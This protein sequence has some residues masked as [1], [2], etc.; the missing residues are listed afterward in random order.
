MPGTN[1]HTWQ[2]YHVGHLLVTI[3]LDAAAGRSAERHQELPGLTRRLIALTETER[4]PVTW[5]VS[6]PAHSAATSLILRS[7]IEHEIAILG[8]LNWVGPTAGRTR[9]ARE[10]MR[11]LSQA[12]ATGLEVTSLIPNVASIEQHVDLVVKQGITAVAGLQEPD[13]DRHSPT[14]RALYY[15]VWELPVSETLPLVSEWFVRGRYSLWRQI[16]RTMRDAGTYHLVIDAPNIAESGRRGEK[17][18]AWLARRISLLR[19]RGMINVHTLRT[20]AARLADVPAQRPQRSILR[21]AA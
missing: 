21:A 12:R 14:P 3:R 5:A 4:L 9:F 18:I 11:R 7:G 17:T 20:M 15:G 10:L 19:D 6:D 1:R 16:R 13:S 8:D 2:Q